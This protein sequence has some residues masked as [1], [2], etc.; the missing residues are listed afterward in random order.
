MG[1][2]GSTPYIIDTYQTLRP[3]YEEE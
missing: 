2:F 1:L 3:D